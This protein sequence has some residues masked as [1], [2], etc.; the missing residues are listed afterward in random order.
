M[1]LIEK[2]KNLVEIFNKFYLI[3]F[4]FSEKQ[5]NVIRNYWE[6]NNDLNFCLIYVLLIDFKIFLREKN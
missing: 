1:T 4:F 2:P 5:N 6:M 3:L